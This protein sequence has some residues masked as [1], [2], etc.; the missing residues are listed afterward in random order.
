[1]KRTIRTKALALILAVL[2]LISVIPASMA[3]NTEARA[4][5][6]SFVAPDGKYVISETDYNIVNGVKET[7]V[8]LNNAEGNAQVYGYMA[9]IVPGASVKFKASYGG[10]YTENSTAESRAENAKNLKWDLRTTTGQAADY[11]KA[12]GETVV[13]AT[14]ADYFD[15]QT[16]QPFGYLIMEGNIVQQAGNTLAETPYF[17][18]LKDGTYAIRDYGTDCS[19]V[20][21]AISGPFY[22]VRNG[23]LQLTGDATLAP[24]NSIG[25]RADGTV[26]TFLADGRAGK[27]AGMTVDDMARIMYANGA[28]NAIYLDGG[29][30]ATFATRHEGADSLTIKNTPSDGPER[31]V[32]SSF[33][34]VSTAKET[35][36]FDHA[37][38]YPRNELYIAKAEVQLTAV[39]VDAGGYSAPIPSTAKWSLADSSFGTIDNNGLFKSNGKCGTVTVNLIVSNKVVG[40]TSI[41][42]QEPDEVFFPAD[43]MNLAF[44][45]SSNFD[46]TARYQNRTM[47]LE[48]FTFQ[49]KITP[50]TPDKTADQIGSITG[51]TFTSVKASETLNAVIEVSYT[52]QDGTVLGDTIAVEIGKMPQVIWD[53]E[54]AEDGSTTKMGIYDWG[55]RN[56]NSSGWTPEKNPLTF[57]A[58]D[59]TAEE[60]GVKWKTESGPFF[61]DGTYLDGPTDVCR[62]PA[63]AIFEA[64][65]Y[66]FFT[67]HTSYMK[68]Y[69]AGGD[70]VSA[71]D[72]EVRFGD[73]ALRWDYDFTDLKPGYRNLNMWLF[74]SKNVTLPGTPTGLGF[75]VYAPEGTPNYWLW[76][77]ISYFDEDGNEKNPYIHLK[78]QEGRNM[79]YTGIYWDGWMYVEADL[80]P[81][82]KYVTPEHPLQILGG[83]SFISLTFIPGGS[84]NENG[85]KIPMGD[86]AK[87]SLY[88]DNFRVVYGDTLDD[89]DA[90]VINK[91]TANN[92]ALSENT[93]TVNS[94][95][96]TIKADFEDPANDNATGIKTE[97]TAIYVDGFKQELTSSTETGAE[98]TVTLPN[99]SH[100]VMLTVTDGF[101]NLTKNTYYIQVA[102]KNSTLGTV[103]LTGEATAEIGK[104]YELQLKTEGSSKIGK[105]HTVISLTDTFGDPTVT[106]ENGYT[107]TSSF[108][109]GKLTVDATANKA[110]LGTVAKITFNVDSSLARDA[111]LNYVVT[112]GSLVDGETNLT[113]GSLP[114]AATVTAHYEIS[115][116][117]MVVNST[118]K[119]YVTN[120]DGSAPGRVEVYRVVD[121]AEPQLLGTTNAAGVLITNQLCRTAGESYVI[122]AKSAD[123]YSFRLSG[124]T[125]A[126][127][128]DDVV[129]TNVRLNAGTDSAT[130]QS[131]SWFS[132]PEYTDRKAVVQY[133]EGALKKT[134]TA[135]YTTVVGSSRLVEFNGGAGDQSVSLINTVKLE[136]LKPGTTYQYRVGDGNE[137]HW[138]ALRQFTTAED[139]ANTSFFVLGDTQLNGN[140]EADKEEIAAMAKIADAV[141]LANVDFGIQTGDFI[142]KASSQAL[143]NQ[144][145]NLFS[146][147]YPSLPLVQ[148][149]GNHEYYGDANASIAEQIFDLPSTDYYSVEYGNVYLAVINC[150]ANIEAAAKW[151]VEDAAKTDCTWKV[152]TVH[153]PPYYTN[154]KGSS[155]PYNKNIPAA[156]EAAGIDF[157]FSGHDHAFARTE[158]IFNGEV[159]EKN[160]VVYYI[161]GDLGEKSRDI[162]YAPENNPDFHFAKITQDYDAVY[163]IVNTTATTMTVTNYD[164]DGSVI[165]TYTKKIEN[166]NP[167]NPDGDKHNYVYDRTT[168]TL[169]CADAD[170]GEVAPKD[171]TGPAKDGK[172]GKNMYFIGGTYKTGWFVLGD[173]IY[174]FDEK[175]GEAHEVT[176]V[177]DVATTCAVQ[178]Y[179]SVKCE[180]GETYYME[181]DRPTGHTNVAKTTD[182]GEVYYVCSNCG[183]ISKYDLTFVDVDDADWFAPEVDYCIRNGLF[184]GRSVLNF[185]PQTS[186]SRV[187]FVSVLWRLAGRPDEKNTQ[188]PIYSDCL[189]GQ[190]YT[191]AINWA[192]TNNIVNGVGD[193]LFAP[194]GKITREQIAT[195]LYRYAK[196]CKMDNLDERG[197]VSQFP[198]ADQISE[199][200]QEAMS[201][202]VGVG[203]LR[204]DPKLGLVPLDNATRAQTAAMI[205]RYHKLMTATPEKPAA[206]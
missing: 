50:V 137:G 2:M 32:S 101:G 22:L 100:S 177:A 114:A 183:R 38:L 193:G 41:E 163:T 16:A 99:G 168:K 130:S 148:V 178:G 64:A 108:E 190:W 66:D 112:E 136:G 88:F 65:G 153:Q 80:T 156:A 203:M 122:Y 63:A 89:M 85:T 56:I 194:D 52:K 28:V 149:L 200:A 141:N 5:A 195:I 198:D 107:G 81:Y 48:G 165:D 181:Y 45:A 40:T 138:S 113:F 73:H 37:S 55:D 7:Q 172:S 166:D 123:G 186:M 199:Y 135:E 96:V 68:N 104:T 25:L 1:M 167:D 74:S 69:A 84:A 117:I 17:A 144:I 18:L 62:Y 185:D 173:E 82:A 204:G 182:D 72:G 161:C 27:S 184:T 77:Q 76:L 94:S 98:A 30:S 187:E 191:A 97:K 118:G 152:L 201:W 26:I 87:G 142:D 134:N 49:W 47:S 79:Q 150:N 140:D 61:F 146:E 23:E 53:F 197:D 189:G 196:L 202:A 151:L 10:Y 170:C 132:A 54:A 75:W 14:N 131:I 34:L 29:G 110:G 93:V 67:D 24:R 120:A 6:A 192:T 147:E 12:T 145:L 139:Q 13:F 59:G 105:I 176:I 179:K 129:P 175:T 188:K 162:S 46:L 31:V 206:E 33:M 116:D 71:E 15:M 70:T 127:G 95:K 20:E 171:Y 111:A 160:G 124:T 91:V 103:T 57:F 8:L 157:V 159:N 155:D 169:T 121:G 109:N 78:T 21:E 36:S 92:T 115:A 102:D 83:R 143:W 125:N 4:S 154:P 158:P 128:N 119:I 133:A 164:L 9:T 19:D 43:S 86:F 126:L 39:G 51:N 106:F 180:C 205:M 174:H 60:G 44:K 11:E 58:W 3:V 35:G 90:P 42:I